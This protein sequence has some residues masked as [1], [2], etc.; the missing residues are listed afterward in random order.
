MILY[1]RNEIF[2]FL[3]HAD[4][5]N[6]IVIYVKFDIMDANMAKIVPCRDYCYILLKSMYENL[7]IFKISI[8]QNNGTGK[9]CISEN[10][11]KIDFSPFSDAKMRP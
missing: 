4:S 9:S 2:V 7:S 8:F 10:R 6:E 11:A 3:L 1:D 5:F